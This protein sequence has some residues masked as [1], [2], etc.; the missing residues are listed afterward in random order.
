MIALS[1]RFQTANR[2]TDR[3]KIDTSAVIKISFEVKMGPNND[4]RQ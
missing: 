4:P 3:A 1:S 2:V